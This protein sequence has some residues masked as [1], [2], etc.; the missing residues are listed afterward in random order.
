MQEIE[1]KKWYQKMTFYTFLQKFL[2]MSKKSS[3]FAPAFE[4]FR[5]VGSRGTFWDAIS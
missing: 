3:T 1:E 2:H 4:M 5:A